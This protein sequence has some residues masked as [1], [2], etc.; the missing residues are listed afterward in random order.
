MQIPYLNIKILP[1]QRS[2][3]VAGGLI[4]GATLTSIA[5]WRSIWQ[6][7]I[8]TKK[9]NYYSSAQITHRLLQEWWAH[10]DVE[11]NGH[12]KTSEFRALVCA[13]FRSIAKDK[14]LIYAY[15]NTMLP[16]H[17]TDTHKEAALGLMKSLLLKLNQDSTLICEELMDRLAVNDEYNGPSKERR[18]N[19][20]E[21]LALFTMWF[22][23]QLATYF[24]DKRTYL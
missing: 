5:I 22:E 8:P 20:N 23:A 19:K 18:L 4:V 16:T 12:L 2:Q 13:V 15:V 10:Y 11:Q 14:G 24:R 1:L 17:A 9:I 7:K 6:R 3:I 21:F